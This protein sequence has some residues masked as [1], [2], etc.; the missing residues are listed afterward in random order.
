MAVRNRTIRAKLVA[1]DDLACRIPLADVQEPAGDAWGGRGIGETDPA[2][3]T[4]RVDDRGGAGR[5]SSA[6]CNQRRG[7]AGE[8]KTQSA[9]MSRNPTGTTRDMRTSGQRDRAWRPPATQ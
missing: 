2:D 4:G 7:R 9:D 6:E 8:R 1:H 3:L 5:E